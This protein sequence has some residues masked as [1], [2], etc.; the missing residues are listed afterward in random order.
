MSSPAQTCLDSPKNKRFRILEV[1]AYQIGICYGSAIRSPGILPSGSKVIAVPPLLQ[2]SVV[3]NHGIYRAGCNAPEQARLS[4]PRDV[5][6]A[7]RIRL[8]NN[9]H[10]VSG[11]GQD[12]SY[13]RNTDMRTVDIGITCNKNYVQALPT[14]LFHLFQRCRKKHAALLY[15]QVVPLL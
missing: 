9:S 7:F 4:Q 3:G 5:L 13:N 2:S 11:P 12:M 10:S 6:P 8:R 15:P 1:S 14:A